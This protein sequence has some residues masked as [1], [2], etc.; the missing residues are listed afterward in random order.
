[1]R[2]PALT[3]RLVLE[4]PTRTA[5][6]A[7]GF[8]T[9]WAD[10]GAL[11]G[12]V[13]TNAPRLSDG[14]GAAEQRTPLRITLRGAPLGAPSRPVP[15]QRFRDGTRRFLI[16]AVQD[17]PLQVVVVDHDELAHTR[18]REAEHGG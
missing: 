2:R 4:E 12:E 18:R 6:G 5:D 9:A 10:K 11:W 14:P 13:A 7:G 8:A 1:M 15:G 3:R 16:E 17:L